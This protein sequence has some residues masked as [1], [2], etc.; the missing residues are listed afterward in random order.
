V[1]LPAWMPPKKL[2]Y[3]FSLSLPPSLI[4]SSKDWHVYALPD[5]LVDLSKLEL[6]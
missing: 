1:R 2:A 6:T 5:C 3:R 4:T